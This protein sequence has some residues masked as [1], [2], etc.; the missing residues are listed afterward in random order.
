ML[1]TVHRSGCARQHAGAPKTIS[2]EFV[3]RFIDD[4]FVNPGTS[5]D[6]SRFQLLTQAREPVHLQDYP[7][8]RL[9]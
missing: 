5:T 8:R 4:N 1:Q 9:L 2:Y 3:K 6:N 7:T